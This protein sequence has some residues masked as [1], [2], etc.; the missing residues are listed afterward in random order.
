MG[1]R[2]NREVGSLFYRWVD[3]QTRAIFVDTVLF[4]VNT[5]LFTIVKFL[6]ESP[7]SGG[8]ISLQD[9]ESIRLYT[10]VGQK[11][12]LLIIMQLLWALVFILSTTRDIFRLCRI[13]GKYFA[14]SWNWVKL[15]NFGA[16]CF[17]L[18]TFGAKTVHIQMAVEE[19]KTNIGIDISYLFDYKTW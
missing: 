14:D 3:D 1:Q 15:V 10:Y 17:T 7:L 2:H 12:F 16:V 13:G 9:I 19:L 5:N 8:L 4:N 18:V 11:G 6:Y